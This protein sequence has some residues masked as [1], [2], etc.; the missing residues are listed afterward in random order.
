MFLLHTSCGNQPPRV[1]SPTFAPFPAVPQT[2]D[3]DRWLE[4]VNG[5]AFVRKVQS[6]ASLTINHERYDVP[7]ELAGQQVACFINAPEKQFDLWQAGSRVKSVP[8]KG[9]SGRTVP[10]E[11]YVELMRAGSSL[12][13]T[14]G[15]CKHI[16]RSARVACGRKPAGKPAWEKQK[17]AASGAE[18]S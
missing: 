11:E 4:R 3:P 16:P 14:G 1:A 10:F 18:N 2:I 9:L 13:N 8:I 15:I 17:S 12:A 5:Q 7:R 6:D